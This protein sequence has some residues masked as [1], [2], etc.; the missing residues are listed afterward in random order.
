M[1]LASDA[2]LEVIAGE[3]AV[4]RTKFWHWIDADKDGCTTRSEVLK[5]EAVVAPEQGPKYA[6]SGGR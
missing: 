2:L 1:R 6:L 3:S 5:A 4:G